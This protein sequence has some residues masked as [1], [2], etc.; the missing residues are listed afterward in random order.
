MKEPNTTVQPYL[1][2]VEDNPRD[3]D[4][5]RMALDRQGEPYQLAALPDGQAALR[6]ILD[7]HVHPGEPLPCVLLLNVHLPKYDG[8]EVLEAIRREP[9]LSGVQVIMLSSGNVRPREEVAIQRWG[10]LFRE[11]PREFSEVLQLAA[12]VLELCKQAMASA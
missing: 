4:L 10:A 9:A 6:F 1:I 8:I 3:I 11:K 5:F 7:R 2:M 12:D